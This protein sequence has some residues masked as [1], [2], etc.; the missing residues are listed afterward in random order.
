M[1]YGMDGY[2]DC[3][4]KIINTTRSMTKE[5]RKIKGIKIMGEPD[6]SVIALGKAIDI[7]VTSTTVH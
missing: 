2:V 4:R 1:Y 3:T 6:V 7:D 5:L